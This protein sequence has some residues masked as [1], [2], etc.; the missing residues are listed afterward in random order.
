MN[1]EV[2][3]KGVRETRPMS[4]HERNFWGAAP[5]VPGNPRSKGEDGTQSGHLRV[6]VW[7]D[8]L[9]T[10]VMSDPRLMG[11][12]LAAL[13]DASFHTTTELPLPDHAVMTNRPGSEFLG[14]LLVDFWFGHAPLVAVVGSDTQRILSMT[15]KWLKGET[16]AS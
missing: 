16:A 9:I 6:E 3:T 2:R 12:A 13:G 14:R 11:P 10:M 5:L 1:N 4:G 8:G 7:A 15:Q